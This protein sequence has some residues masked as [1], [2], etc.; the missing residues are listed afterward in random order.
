MSLAPGFLQA[1][2]LMAAASFLCRA[3]GFFLMRYVPVTPRL[4][5]ALRAL[6]FGVML[7][8]AAPVVLQGR[9]PESVGLA[10]VVLVMAWRGNDL[11]AA[12][13]GVAAVALLRPL[14]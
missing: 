8:I 4:E 1:L 6:P 9:V 11:L 12:L 7:G 14:V 2:L 10:L 3:G 13:T 5:A